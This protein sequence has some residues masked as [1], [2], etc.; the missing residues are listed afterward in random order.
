MKR[1]PIVLEDPIC[2]T[3]PG[4]RVVIYTGAIYG[5]LKEKTR[6]GPDVKTDLFMEERERD[7]NTRA[8]VWTQTNKVC[9]CV[10]KEGWLSMRGGVVYGFCRATHRKAPSVMCRNDS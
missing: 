3:E 7:G 6:G 8:A 1:D 2:E 5:A 9:F 4:R 10:K